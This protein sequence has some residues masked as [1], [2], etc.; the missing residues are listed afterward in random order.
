MPDRRS[1]KFYQA[2]VFT[3]QPFGGNPVA[4]FPEADG[5]TDDEL[6]QIAREMNLSET[7]F[8]LPPTDPAAVVRL[9]IFTPTQELPFAGHPVI[10]T[11]YLLAQLNLLPLKDS[12]TRLMYECNIGLFPVELH[13]E[14][15]RIGRVVMSQPKP[16]FLGPVE[17][18][19]DLY[20][21]A[22]S[23]GL[24]KHLGLI[25]IGVFHL[26]GPVLLI[27]AGVALLAIELLLID[28][29]AFYEGVTLSR[30]G[31]TLTELDL[32]K[33]NTTLQK[34]EPYF[35]EKFIHR[36]EGQTGRG[37]Q[38][39]MIVTY[40]RAKGSLL[41]V[42]TYKGEFSRED[43]KR[44]VKLVMLQDVGP[45][46]QITKTRNYNPYWAKPGTPLPKHNFSSALSK[47]RVAEE[48]KDLG[49]LIIQ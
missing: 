21:V 40:C 29:A 17:E 27:A 12:V 34:S 35:P 10:G 6:Q 48:P 18:T 11:F 7:V 22:S 14:G 33:I 13:A 1:L 38:A 26:I 4:V 31:N 36:L 47:I 30:E 41:L 43:H 16:E 39:R 8:V 24:A 32:E 5:L 20:K 19:E 37:N 9:R 46:W 3:T 15:E 25:P 2:D 49:N 45:G 42:T 28:A 23:L 44:T